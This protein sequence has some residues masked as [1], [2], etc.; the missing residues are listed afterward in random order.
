MAFRPQYTNRPRFAPHMPAVRSV[1]HM[2]AGYL[3]SKL[4]GDRTVGQIHYPQN[5]ANQIH[6]PQNGAGPNFYS[7]DNRPIYEDRGKVVVWT[8]RNTGVQVNRAYRNYIGEE[9]RKYV[10]IEILSRAQEFEELHPL[11]ILYIRRAALEP[12]IAGLTKC[13]RDFEA[14]ENCG[15]HI[16]NVSGM[17]LSLITLCFL[18]DLIK[19]VE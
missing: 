1:N 14:E 3:M 5:A 18:F 15:G 6:Y 11:R 13:L 2:D 7:Q 17:V 4:G 19:H 12:F 10:G 16:G 8:E 9:E